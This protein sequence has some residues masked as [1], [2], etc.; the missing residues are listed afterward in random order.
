MNLERFIAALGPTEV[1]NEAPVEIADLAYDTRA[2]TPGT[3]FFC[4]RGSRAD[5]HPYAP[6]AVAAGAVAVVVERPLD[7]AV[8]Q[9]V[10]ANVRAAMPDAAVAFFGDPSRELE[11]AGITGTNGKTTTAFLLHAI[12]NTAG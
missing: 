3:L 7:V 10:V 9:L 5:G 6:T 1:V 2:T 4:V 8:P 12:L 11:V